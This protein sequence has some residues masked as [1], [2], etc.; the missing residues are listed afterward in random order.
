M[1]MGSDRDRE[2]ALTK[3]LVQC[4]GHGHIAVWAIKVR[5]GVAG[6]ASG[7]R[8]GSFRRSWSVIG[9]VMVVCGVG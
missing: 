7:R 1:G 6:L 8:Y 3:E 9:C 2:E 5:I 4:P